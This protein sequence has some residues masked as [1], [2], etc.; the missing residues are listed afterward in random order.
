MKSFRHRHKRNT[1]TRF[2]LHTFVSFIVVVF[3][4]RSE[5][6]VIKRID[7]RLYVIVVETY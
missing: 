2:V 6:D 7:K 4:K 1:F 5:L 3:I